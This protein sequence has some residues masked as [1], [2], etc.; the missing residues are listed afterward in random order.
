MQGDRA[1]YANFLSQNAMVDDAVGRVREALRKRGLAERTV[2]VYSAD[3]GNLFGQHGSWGHTIW[4]TPARL[5]DETVRVPLIVVHP[6]GGA[7]SVSER[8]VGQYDMAPT[9]L[10]FAGV[11]DVAFENSAGQSFAAAARGGDSE[12]GPDAVYFEQEETRGLRTARHLYWKPLA[13]LGEPM[14]FD[15]ASDPAQ[16]NDLYPEQKDGALVAELDAKLGAFFARH[17]D[18]GYD[19][20]QTGVSKGTPPKPF[21]WLKRNPVPWL[22]KYFRDHVLPAPSAPPF[23]ETPL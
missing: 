16:R 11:N 23:E 5:Y 1:S 18:A 19:L 7:G 15:L 2:I 6:Q 17:S 14:L 8:L 10:E 9:L 4:F 21:L 20:W 12:R 22:Q 13:D 3:Q